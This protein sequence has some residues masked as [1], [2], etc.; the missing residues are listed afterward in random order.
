MKCGVTFMSYRRKKV[1]RNDETIHELSFWSSN[2]KNLSIFVLIG[3]LVCV[4]GLFTGCKDS[5]PTDGGTLAPYGSGTVSLNS[6]RGN[7]SISGTGTLSQT[8]QGVIAIFDTVTRDL[9]IDAFQ[10]TTGSRAN[11]IFIVVRDSAG[12]QQKIYGL[13]NFNFIGVTFNADSAH[14]DS[15]Y[16]CINGYVVIRTVTGTT[17]A[18]DFNAEGNNIFT[19][20]TIT[21]SNG[22]FNINYV[23]GRV[24]WVSPPSPPSGLTA[25]P[26]SITVQVGQNAQAQISG[27]TL[28]Y[29]I[30]SPPNAS[31]A[32]AII[33]GTSTLVI[34]GIGAGTTSVVV[35]DNSTP[36]QTLTMPITVISGGLDLTGTWSGTFTTSIITTPTPV[37]LV[38]SQSSSNVTGTYSSQAGGVGTVSGTLNGNTLTFSLQQTTTGCS[39]TFSGT[40]TV[41]GNTMTFTFSGNDCLG[42]HSNGQGTVTRSTSTFDS[43]FVRIKLLHLPSMLTFNQSHVPT[44][45]AEYWWGILFNT[46]GDTSTGLQGYDIEIALTRFKQAGNPFQASVIQGT[47]HEVIEWIGTSGYVMHSNVAAWIDPVDSNMLVMAAP[48]SWVEISRIDEADSF[49]IHTF[50]DAPS[51]PDGYDETRV[52]VGTQP[53]NDPSGDTSYDFVDIVFCGWNTHLLMKNRSKGIVRPSGES[54]PTSRTNKILQWSGGKWTH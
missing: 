30:Q 38:L 17:I 34:N 12:I 16:A 51:P 47:Q 15:V 7:L 45:Y 27:G 32:T 18:G 20:R 9:V 43:V 46:D 29:E 48:R 10:P 2:M 21:V 40:G 19:G 14:T 37:T 8:G 23:R 42:T 28:P 22:S 4:N 53:I 25:N 44:D 36:V 35:R 3:L 5:S 1:F 50:Y 33:G 54:I 41:S 11:G 31:I 6:N 24:P 52:A 26:S 49:Y 13:G 39:G